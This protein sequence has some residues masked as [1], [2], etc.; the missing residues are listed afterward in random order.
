MKIYRTQA[1][2]AQGL[3]ESRGSLGFVPT[4]GALHDG[5]LS[6]VRRAQEENDAVAVSIFV[7]P[8]QFGAREDLSKY[9][10]TE[11]AD[12]EK[13]EGLSVD[14]VFVGEVG[15]LYPEGFC[16]AV[17]IQGEV[18]Q[19]LEGERRP[20]HFDGVCT[21]VAKLFH[22]FQP[23]R[24]Y[25]GWKDFQQVCVLRRMVQD[26][27]FPVELHA[28]PI[29]READ[30]LAMSSRNRFLSGADR[31]LAARI[32]EALSQARKSVRHGQADVA[33][34][35]ASVKERLAGDFEVEYV[36]VRDELD[37][38]RVESLDSHPGRARMLLVA[39]IGGVRLLDNLLLNPR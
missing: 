18:T 19:V 32:H 12:L 13:L 37:F 14:H 10:R 2:L 34:L 26:L 27:G 11:E 15:D 1:A 23:D 4:M 25:F 30:G 38:G 35:C 16:T 22:L 8:L 9:P 31:G 36:E 5:H 24:A 3:A 6:L 7:N 29:E 28:C 33:R 20:G 21:V 17:V 39:K